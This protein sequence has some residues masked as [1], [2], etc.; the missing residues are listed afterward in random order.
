MGPKEIKVVMDYLVIQGHLEKQ[1]L[2]DCLDLLVIMVEM[3]IKDK[4]ELLDY[5]EHLD[6]L[7]KEELMGYQVLE[8]SQDGPVLKDRKD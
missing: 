7:V 4:Q 1:E 8:D 3:E 5:L 6:H 2:L